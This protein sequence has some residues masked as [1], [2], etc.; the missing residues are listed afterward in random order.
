[1]CSERKLKRDAQWQLPARSSRIEGS[2]SRRCWACQRWRRWLPGWRDAGAGACRDTPPEWQLYCP[3]AT[4]TGPSANTATRQEYI[5]RQYECISKHCNTTRVHQIQIGVLVRDQYY[6][7][8]YCA[9]DFALV[10]ANH[11]EGFKKILFIT[12]KMLLWV[13]GWSSYRQN[14][15]MHCWYVITY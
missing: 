11:L 9:D 15:W 12:F 7:P 5:K 4:V 14:T 1:M 2:Q 13:F 10:S 6:T 3:S 8:S